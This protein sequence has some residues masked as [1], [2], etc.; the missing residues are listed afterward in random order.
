MRLQKFLAQSGIA[1]RRKSEELIKNGIIKVN[2]KIISEMGYKIDPE[3]DKIYVNDKEIKINNNKIYIMLNKPV[4]YITTLSDE[5]NRKKVIDL[6]N[7]KER[8]FPIGRLDYDTSGL[9]LLTNDGDLTHKL[10]HPSFEI[11]KT[12]IA[13][14]K[15]ILTK[16]EIKNFENGLMIEDYI[17][18]PAKLDV[19][20]TNTDN[21]IIKISIREGKNRQVRKMCAAIGHPVIDLKRIAIDNITLGNLPEGE[22]RYLSDREINHLKNL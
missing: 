22:Y 1:S 13:K 14:V 5:F 9:L 12:Y 6:I 8:I 15:G 2:N 11:I 3:K 4:G 21:S 18:S 17:T 20:R 7:I 10:T 16:D 19:I